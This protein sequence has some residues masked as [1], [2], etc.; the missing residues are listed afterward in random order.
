M[1][2]PETPGPDAALDALVR[3]GERFGRTERWS[4][5]QIA[6]F[7]AAAGDANPL[8]HDAAHAAGT[9]FKVPIASGT[10]T[11]SAMMGAFA[12]WFTRRDD[13]VERA[14]VGVRFEFG[15]KRP[16]RAGDA[17]RIEWEVVSRAYEPRHGGWRVT[18]RG[19]A[20][21]PEGVALEAE[22]TGL[23]VRAL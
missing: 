23:V 10:Q 17:L 1:S 3:V 18:A 13:G 4:A 15:L 22:G 12:T 19:T 21:T 9:R 20:S 6:A 16:V 2:A 14:A 7:A 5:G 8:H 11:M